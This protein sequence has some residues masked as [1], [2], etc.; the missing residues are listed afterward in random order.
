M[1]GDILATHV[2]FLVSLGWGGVASTVGYSWVPGAEGGDRG[3][4]E[5]AMGIAG[6]TASG[7][8]GSVTRVRSYSLITDVG[9]ELGYA[10]R[11][12]RRCNSTIPC[13]VGL[14]DPHLPVP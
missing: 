5:V 8:W 7:G 13:Y 6:G 12:S 1:I 10:C 4:Q 14:W 9:N 11:I 3:I 2:S